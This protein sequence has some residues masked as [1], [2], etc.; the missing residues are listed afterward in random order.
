M[1]SNNKSSLVV[2]VKG[3][4]TASFA[5]PL[6]CCGDSPALAAAPT[7]APFTSTTWL[8]A[9]MRETKT[10]NVRHSARAR[11]CD[12]ACACNEAAK[13]A[14]LQSDAESVRGSAWRRR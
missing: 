2:R 5:S 8:V 4:E 9:A 11:T 14:R 12:R 1:N 6:S 3:L 10:V 7:R 13:R